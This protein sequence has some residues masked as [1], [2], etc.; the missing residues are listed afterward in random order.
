MLKKISGITLLFLFFCFNLTYAL[1]PS[2]F[3]EPI[4]GLS[5]NAIAELVWDG[6]WLWAGTVD[7]VSRTSDGGLNWYTYNS[8][9][10]LAYDEVTA[11]AASDS[12]LWVALAYSTFHQGEPFPFGGGFN[13][14]TDLGNTWKRIQPPQ[15][16]G[17]YYKLAF[18]IAIVDSVVWAAC[19]YGGLL[20]FWD[21]DTWENVFV[22]S[23][24]QQDFE[25]DNTANNRNNIF[26][27]VIADTF[28][29]D[30]LFL[31][32]GTCA[33]IYKFIYTTDDSADTVIGYNTQEDT[34]SGDFVF[35]L[36]VQKHQD[37]K[38]IW[39]GTRTDCDGGVFGACKSTDH[40]QTWEIIPEL[41]GYTVNN[42]DFQDSMIWAATNS[43]L[44]R[45]KDWGET[46]EVF[47]FMEDKDQP[48]QKVFSTEFYSIKIIG[49]TIWAGNA[50][51]LV[52]TTDDGDTW[53]VYRSFVPIGEKGAETA[54]AYPNPFSSK[55]FTQVIRI[56]YKPET[57]GYV[58]IKIY[59]FAMNLVKEIKAGQKMGGIE[60][61]EIWDGK[62]DQGD[63]VANGTYFFK[64]EAP[65]QTEW[66]KIVVIK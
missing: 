46:W 47:N 12:I 22:D 13:K 60:Y 58:S 26:F 49:N 33:G 3:S 11:M 35:A 50:D 34:L 30:T 24:A 44:K 4:S 40:G 17:A 1:M 61:D 65:G 15:A 38:I 19:I 42:Y 57:D 54:Y 7:G 5:G 10:G 28:S 63:V 20:R 52:K 6:T 25:E 45:S 14:T 56:H 2:H 27:A 59:D 16:T 18:D 48:D 21:D 32:T 55:L 9:N 36:A 62:N 39:A 53:K 31:W 51:G 41:E 37:K 23:F 8:K 64:V 29:T 66:G 43:G